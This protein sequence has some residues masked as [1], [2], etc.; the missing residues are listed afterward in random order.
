MVEK[1]DAKPSAAEE[2]A[3]AAKSAAV[4]AADVARVSQ[5]ILTTKREGRLNPCVVFVVSNYS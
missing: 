3:A 4:A 2:A 1:K 5:E